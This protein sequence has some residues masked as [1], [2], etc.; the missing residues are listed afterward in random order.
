MPINTIS[1]QEFA[2]DVAAAQ[3]AAAE[4]PVFITDHGAPVFVLL[5]I[6]DYYRLTGNSEKSL[7]ELMAVMPKQGIAPDGR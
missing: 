2:L 5:R 1:S 6:D 4:G 7:L 3:R